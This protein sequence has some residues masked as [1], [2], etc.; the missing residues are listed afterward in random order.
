MLCQQKHSLIQYVVILR[1]WRGVHWSGLLWVR[2][3]GKIVCRPGMR[4]CAMSSRMYS[5]MNQACLHIDNWIM[6]LIWLMSHCR[7]LNTGST[8]SARWSRLRWSSKSSS[9]LTVV[10]YVPVCHR[11]VHQYCSYEKRLVNYVCA[12]I[13]IVSTIRWGSMYFPY[14]VLLTCS[15]GWVRQLYSTP[16]TLAM[17]T[18]RFAYTRATSLKLPFSHCRGCRSILSSP[19]GYAMCL[20]PSTADELNVLRPKPLHDYVPGWYPGI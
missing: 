5:V 17:H 12:L 4:S 14:C 7:C 15:T 3:L 19:L 6:Q 13:I 9:C 10:G 20:P 18:I 8:N 2:P 11:M 1:V 16:S